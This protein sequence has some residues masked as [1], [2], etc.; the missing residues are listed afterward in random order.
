MMDGLELKSP[1]KKTKKVQDEES[2]IKFEDAAAINWLS[3]K[4]VCKALLYYN[5]DSSKLKDIEYYNK[6]LLLCN[7]FKPNDIRLVF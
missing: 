3:M 4:G 6:I 2:T 7:Y 5:E 1:T